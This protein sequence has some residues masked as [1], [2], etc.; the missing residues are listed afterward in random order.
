MAVVE[1]LEVKN[2]ILTSWT[3]SRDVMDV[4]SVESWLNY[5]YS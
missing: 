4:E 5:E 1:P 2:L 3:I